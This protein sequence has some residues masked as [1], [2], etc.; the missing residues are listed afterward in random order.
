MNKKI[1]GAVAAGV[2]AMGGVA[3]A[4]SAQA[5]PPTAKRFEHLSGVGVGT[6]FRPAIADPNRQVKVIVQLAGDSVVGRAAKAKRQGGALTA[7]QRAT[8]RAQL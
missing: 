3:T 5:D 1:L 4:A 7:G 8:L 2:L 6:T